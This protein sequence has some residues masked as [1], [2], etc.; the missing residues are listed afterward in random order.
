[1]TVFSPLGTVSIGGLL[2][3]TP[4]GQK[5]TMVCL[6]GASGLSAGGIRMTLGT[7][8]FIT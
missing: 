1:M 7:S 8:L 4:M 5:T 6:M 3:V 2:H